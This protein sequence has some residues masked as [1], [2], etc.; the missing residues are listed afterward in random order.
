[1]LSLVEIKEYHMDAV[2]GIA[3]DMFVAALL[4]LRPDL[5]K[6][7]ADAITLMR[8]P[9]NVKAVLERYDDKIF[10]GHRF[11]VNGV[12]EN[13]FEGHSDH[14]HWSDIKEKIEESG[15]S[16]DV[17]EV[18]IK[19]FTL[20]AEA[21]AF[22]HGIEVENVSFHEV[23][24]YDSLIDI[25]SAAVIISSLS[26]CHWF[27]G[28]IPKGSGLVSSDH[29]A[30]PV[31]APATVN[32]LEGF[33]LVDDE[34]VGERVTPTGAAILRYLNPSQKHHSNP[35]KLVGA[36][37]GFG[38][39]KLKSRSNILRVVSF[40]RLES[41]LRGDQ[42]DVLRCEIDD[43]TAE[44]LAVAIDNLRQISGV[45]DVCQWSV[46]AKKGRIASA[47][48]ILVEPFIADDVINR[49]FDET[50]TLGVRISRQN[51][52]IVLRES[53]EIDGVRVKIVRRP[54]GESA[55]AEM[56][57]IKNEKLQQGR[58][59][60]RRKVEDAALKRQE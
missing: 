47:L 28:L 17:S 38:A 8:F 4:D 45:I 18:T 57:D 49:L 40:D 13:S 15:L 30:L 1:M 3:G 54:A 20:L 26:P 9:D 43:Q 55:K 56:D 41:G 46:F 10:C 51:R 23:G 19:I 14:T 34:E 24:A 39:R 7:C 42:V 33:L 37:V 25:I 16:K 59:K 11:Y 21:E 32:L 22:V 29:G 36:G 44:D 48:Q 6:K 31:P 53:V 12:R 35:I 50:T 52:K 5:W 58:F 2:G 27:I 60:V